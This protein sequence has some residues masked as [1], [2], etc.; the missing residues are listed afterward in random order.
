MKREKIIMLVVMILAIVGL[1]TKNMYIKKLEKQKKE[2]L[3]EVSRY[4]WNYEHLNYVCNLEG[5]IE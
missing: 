4:K 1:G 3:G 5:E 2:L